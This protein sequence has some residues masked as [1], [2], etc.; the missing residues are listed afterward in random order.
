MIKSEK[1]L[2]DLTEPWDDWEN[3]ACAGGCAER[4][5]E[6]EWLILLQPTH[7]RDV[8]HT[9]REKPKPTYLIIN[10]SIMP[11]AAAAAIFGTRTTTAASVTL[12]QQLTHNE[13]EAVAGPC[14]ASAIK[15]VLLLL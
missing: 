8:V 9:L 13:E 12:P 3:R 11:G 4:E 14:L 15:G 2:L 6:R 1:P 10:S 5:R 7:V